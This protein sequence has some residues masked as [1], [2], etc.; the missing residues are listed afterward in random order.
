MS[1]LRLRRVTKE[2]AHC[3]DTYKTDNISVE[4]MDNSPFHLRGSFRGPQDGLY[5]GGNF[6]VDIVLP[7]GY[8]FY[9]PKVKF[10]TKV[11]HPNI[12]SSGAISI[13]ILHHQWTPRFTL[14]TLLISLQ[15]FLCSPELCDPGPDDPV[16]AG[17]AKQFASSRKAF[18]DTAR[19]WTRRY[20]RRSSHP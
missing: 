6:E 16:D 2:I 13:D 17:V 18:E 20:A 3:N 12:S 5:E 14:P 1:D 8:P 10:I 7:D 15:S 11:Y 4:L 9:P 19:N